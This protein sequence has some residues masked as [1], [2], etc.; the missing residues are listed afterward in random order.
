MTSQDQLRAIHAHFTELVAERAA[1][2]QAHLPPDGV[3]PITEDL[4]AREKP[5]WL[6]VPG[7]YGG[8]S[9]RLFKEGDTFRLHTESW[10]RIM[11]GSGQ[12][13]EI[14]AEGTRYLGLLGV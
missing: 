12:A 14:T 10:C 4:L 3:P 9:Y 13:H 6:P 8:F 7:M 11:D 5:D 2:Y 1:R